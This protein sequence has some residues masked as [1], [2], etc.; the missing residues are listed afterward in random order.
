[1]NN[2]NVVTFKQDSNDEKLIKN[3]ESLIKHIQANP[4]SVE[5]FVIITFFTN[6]IQVAAAHEMPMAELIGQL[7]MAK[8][9]VFNYVINDE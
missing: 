9:A 2:L 3:L 5:E 7:E 8:Q 6:G 1:M 4:N